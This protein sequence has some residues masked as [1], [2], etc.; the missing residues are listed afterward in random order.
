[1]RVRVETW[2]DSLAV[3]IPGSLTAEASL[4]AGSEVDLTVEAGRLSISS[5]HAPQ[6]RLD[7]LL[8]GISPENV[9]SEIAT[10]ASVGAESW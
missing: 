2:G 8:A 4:E 1:M 5:A 3:R 6:Y 10:G 7:D 9:H